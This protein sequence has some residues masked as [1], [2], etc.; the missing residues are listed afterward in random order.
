M[1]INEL[2]YLNTVIHCGPGN[3][4]LRRPKKHDNLQFMYNSAASHQTHVPNVDFLLIPRPP[5]PS[6]TKAIHALLKE[7][8]WGRPAA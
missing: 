7:P 4:Y 2:I 1:P 8:P 6:N 5:M 3:N